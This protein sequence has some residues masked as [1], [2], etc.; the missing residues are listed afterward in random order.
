MADRV[1]RYF[2]QNIPRHVEDLEFVGHRLEE[3]HV[4]DGDVVVAEVQAHDVV[5]RVNEG[6]VDPQHLQPIVTDV[7]E[8]VGQIADVFEGAEVEVVDPIEGQVEAAEAVQVLKSEIGQSFEEIAL[9][10]QLEKTIHLVKRPE[11]ENGNGISK[12]KTFLSLSVL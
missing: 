4:D 8:E 11:G 5:E 7:D 12:K 2:A 9:E 3:G 10:I 6:A 1:R